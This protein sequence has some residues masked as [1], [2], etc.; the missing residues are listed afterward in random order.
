[1]RSFCHVKDAA[2]G[3]LKV[4]KHGKDN[5]IYN[6][7]NNSEPININN[8]ANKMVKISKKKCT[9]KKIPFQKSDRSAKEKFI[10]VCP[11]YQRLKNILNIKLR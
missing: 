11:N 1:M 9:I 4:L 7:G 10:F 3:L 5:E 8:L 2:E 6:I